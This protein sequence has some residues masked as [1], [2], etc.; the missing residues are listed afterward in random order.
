MILTRMRLVKL[1]AGFDRVFV[2]CPGTTG[3]AAH[4]VPN[5]RNFQDFVNAGRTVQNHAETAVDCFSDTGSAAVVQSNKAHAACAVSGKALNRHI[6]HDVGTVLDVGGFAEGGVGAGG[7]VVIAS[8][9]NRTDF[10]LTN[11]FVKLQRNLGSSVC[12]LIQDTALCTDNQFVFLCIANPNPVVAVL[13]TSIR[14]DTFHRGSVGC[15]QIFWFAGQAA[16][17]ER[18]VA[19]IEQARTQNIFNIGR[20]HKSVYFVVPVLADFRNASIVNG[21]QE[22]VSVIEEV[23]SFVMQF[24]D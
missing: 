15:I 14:I 19:V 8:E 5:H 2:S 10:S 24:A 11:H 21:F 22:A 13:I 18:T 20:E 16:P 7:I 1:N 17:T 6:C 23:G 12:V 3:N 9:H 4:N